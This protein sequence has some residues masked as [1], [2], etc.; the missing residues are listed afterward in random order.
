MCDNASGTVRL[1]RILFDPLAYI[2]PSRFDA[3]RVPEEAGIRSAVNDVLIEMYRLPCQVPGL[4]R[5]DWSE[6]FVDHWFAL[7]HVVFLLGCHALRDALPLGGV[8]RK[9]PGF[10]RHFAAIPLPAQP[11]GIRR[12]VREMDIWRQGALRLRPFCRLLPEALLQRLMIMLP[13]EAAEFLHSDPE[14]TRQS[15]D[16]VILT[17]AVQ[18]ATRNLYQPCRF[19]D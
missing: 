9:V 6:W 8:W 19:R 17:L 3:E 10:A 5:Q 15:R 7:P 4:S 11:A 2:H 16:P 12:T 13:E 18:H 14:G 1:Q